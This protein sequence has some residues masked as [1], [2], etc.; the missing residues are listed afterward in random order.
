MLKT[1]FLDVLFFIIIGH[2]NCFAQQQNP[3]A[4]SQHVFD[5]LEK[6]E[7]LALFLS[8]HLDTLILHRHHSLVGKNLAENLKSEY[9][10]HQLESDITSVWNTSPTFLQKDLQQ[11]VQSFSEE[12]LF[13]I[14]ICLDNSIE[15]FVDYGEGFSRRN[16]NMIAIFHILEF[17]P[18][19]DTNIQKY[20]G[21]DT[22]IEDKFRY[23][24]T[25]S[26]YD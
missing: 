8:E 23:V 5:N 20:S 25:E 11:L 15:L 3:H 19:L 18:K 24:I 9:C 2:L 1:C 21:K 26:E 14:T 16:D 10:I 17:M 22:L 4:Y 13:S 6:Y 12:N 7:E